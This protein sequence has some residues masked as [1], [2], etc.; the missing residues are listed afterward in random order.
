MITEKNFNV[1]LSLGAFIGAGIATLNDEQGH[2]VEGVFIPIQA[3]NLI[4][5][6]K[7]VYCELRAFQMRE[8]RVSEN[9]KFTDTHILK[10]AVPKEI[11]DKMSD[12]ERQS[13]PIVGS[14]N[15]YNSDNAQS[16]VQYGSA[17]TA[18]QPIAQQP[19]QHPTQQPYQPQGGYPQQPYGG[20]PQ[21]PPVA[22]PPVAQIPSVDD[23]DLP[24]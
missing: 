7:G 4:K 22:Q 5:G 18:A 3:N 12:E 24:F 10:V 21:T 1:K 14:V 11:Y 13:G 2:P 23:P 8:P 19:V 15:S 20:Y 17:P 16:M 6:N 9:G